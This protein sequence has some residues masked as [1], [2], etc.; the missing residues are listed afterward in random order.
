[1]FFNSTGLCHAQLQCLH[2][3]LHIF[4][5]PLARCYQRAE[6]VWLKSHSL[7]FKPIANT[8]ATKSCSFCKI[9]KR[10]PM[11]REWRLHLS[12][13]SLNSLLNT[14]CPTFQ[15]FQPCW[16]NTTKLHVWRYYLHSVTVVCLALSM[17]THMIVS[18]YEPR[19]SCDVS[20]VAT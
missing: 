6:R 8:L 5:S 3:I 20:S 2:I 10:L 1:M 13:A 4:Q 16:L 14:K 9:L 7:T 19:E 17:T 11:F 18:R 15:T 12:Y